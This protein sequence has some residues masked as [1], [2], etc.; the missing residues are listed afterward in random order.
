[1][2]FSYEWLTVWDTLVWYSRG[3]G[4]VGGG[5][6]GAGGVGG[7]GGGAIAGG[8]SEVGG[9]SGD[10]IGTPPH[11][12]ATPRPP[13]PPRPSPPPTHTVIYLVICIRCT[14]IANTNCCS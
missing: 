4:G 12:L 2:N 5:V 13:R 3:G 6:V 7:V 9:G 10:A 1:M 14:N 11:P 8:G